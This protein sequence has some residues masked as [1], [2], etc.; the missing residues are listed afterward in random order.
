[1]LILLA[2][3]ATPLQAQ[4]TGGQP[5][6]QGQPQGVLPGGASSLSETHE[7]W[8]VRCQM[9]PQKDATKPVCAVTQTQVN[10]QGKQVISIEL[11]PS[12]EGLKGALIM[13]FGL[14]INRP[15]TLSIDAGPS[16]PESFS[17]CIPVGCVVPIEIDRDILSAMRGGAAMNVS[18]FTVDDRKLSLPVSLKGFSA[19]A[20][21]V[22][23][24]V[25]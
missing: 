19:A 20:N 12:P 1:M 16:I 25:Q 3:F 13:P 23:E 22:S 18:A 15:V 5:Q 21:R 14:A 6:S 17:T 24:L 2:L 10:P 4:Q 8:T 7:D 9:A 11:R